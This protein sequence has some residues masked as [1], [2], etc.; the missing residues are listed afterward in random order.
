MSVM[1]IRFEK[2]DNQSILRTSITI[3]VS[4]IIALAISGILIASVGANP[5][6]V[7]QKMLE[8]VFFSSRGIE[9]MLQGSLPLLFCGLGV[10]LTFKMNL[11]NI[12]AEGQYAIG[13]IT[14]AAFVFYGPKVEGVLGLVLVAL[15]CFIGGAVWAFICALPKAFWN[16]NESITTLMMNYVALIIL[17]Y[18]C[19]GPWKM[20]GQNV[21]RTDWIPEGLEL[22]SFLIGE[23]EISV[24][25]IIGIVIAVLI[26]C[27][28]K[29][30]T[31]GYQLLVISKNP[32]AAKYAGISIKKNILTVMALSGGLAGLAGF[33]QYTGVT[34]HLVEGM[35]NDA[36]YTAI[37]IAYLSRLN[38]LAVVVVSIL[39]AGLQI[40]SPYVQ[41]QGVPSE[42]ATMMQGVIMICVIAGEFFQRYKLVVSKEG[43]V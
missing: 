36:G 3:L 30:T 13:A 27:A 18:L 33:V 17:S 4:V 8:K 24:G 22:P 23:M 2:R 37:V 9:K 26:F 10:A 41:S 5:V 35:P 16:V 32:T 6:A 39:F 25:I 20:K 14:G 38:P 34:R 40:S 15:A 28:Y 21:A 42:I 11:S 12:G 19:M 7:Y 29:Y 1:K 31:G 43:K